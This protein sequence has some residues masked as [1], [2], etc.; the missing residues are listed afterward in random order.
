MRKKPYP[1]A[2]RV[3]RGIPPQMITTDADGMNGV[4]GVGTLTVIASDG[5]GWDH[6]SVSH[7]TRCPTWREM[8]RVR[9]CFFKE[10]EWVVQYSPPKSE[11]V[12]F[13]E[14]CLHLWRPQHGHM[15]TPPKRLVG[16]PCPENAKE[17]NELL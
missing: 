7:P 17:V 11:H 12:N 3:T 16:A 6:V 14:T 15:P 4:F 1:P 10:N 8:Q 5:D 2:E 13:M 9:E